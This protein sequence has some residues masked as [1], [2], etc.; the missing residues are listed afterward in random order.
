MKRLSAQVSLAADRALL[1]HVGWGF[2]ERGQF[3]A[4]AAQYILDGIGHN[5]WIEFIAN[6]SPEQLHTE[7]ASMPGLS[8]RV[9]AGGIGAT[10]VSQ[11]Y[12]IG[13]GA[14]VIDPHSAVANYVVAVGKAIHHGYAG[15]RIVVDATA[16]ARTAQ[17]RDALA[18]HEF[19][20]GQ[21]MALLPFASL[22]AY[23]TGQLGDDAANELLCL[24]PHVDGKAP[25]VRLHAAPGT[26]FALTGDIDA[27]SNALYTTALQRIWSLS[28]DDPVIIDA[29]G[30][31]FITHRQ[32]CTLD[33]HA[34]TDGRHVLLRT[35]QRIVARLAGLL[36]LTNIAGLPLRRHAHART[37]LTER[38]AGCTPVVSV[39]TLEHDV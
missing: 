1:P 16:L 5:Q 20:I 17:H 21:T 24:H 7:L 25:S 36:D 3:R 30:L 11:F 29:Q 8:E 13:S 27:A 12:R 32:L 39:P 22:C 18:R 35:D 33:Q 9:D 4:Y 19:L 15:V 10:P 6:E 34:R 38:R 28:A 26:S 2:G 23:D 14:H 31:E 37:G